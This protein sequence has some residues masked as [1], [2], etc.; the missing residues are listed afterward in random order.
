MLS[1]ERMLS[2]VPVFEILR[3]PDIP[4]LEAFSP[5]ID[6]D[7]RQACLAIG[8]DG[9]VASNSNVAHEIGVLL[10]DFP[11]IN[12][13]EH[14]GAAANRDDSSHDDFFR[15]RRVEG[16]SYGIFVRTIIRAARVLSRDVDE[17]PVTLAPARLDAIDRALSD[18]LSCVLG[19]PARDGARVTQWK[20]R[21]G[22]HRPMQRWV[23]GHQV[24]AAITQGLIFAFQ[25]IGVQ[26]HNENVGDCGHL[27]DLAITLL[28]GAA[29]ALEFTGDFPPE[30]YSD[31]I[32]PSMRPPFV[33]ETFSGLLS[34][35]HRHFVKTLRASKPALDVIRERDTFRHDRLSQAV[36][37][38]Y[39]SHKFVCE[40]FVGKLPSLRLET[41]S[42]K[43]GVEQLEHFR[44]LRMKAFEPGS[45][46]EREIAQ[47]RGN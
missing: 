19:A 36:S 44:T 10:D 28:A 18:L 13:R 14:S 6:P 25:E 23:R 15:I 7:F 38:V 24:F 29:A 26:A 41:S 9:A 31:I 21:G 20:T 16:H 46:A 17:A 33:S 22:R 37:N 5:G 11:I 3:P 35:D 1:R 30:D 34:I 43:S 39:E 27:V 42:S 32:R 45:P 8:G 2:N 4:T 47:R 12:I 40:R